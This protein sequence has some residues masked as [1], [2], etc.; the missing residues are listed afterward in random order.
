MVK[1][2]KDLTGQKFGKLTVL[3]QVEDL[4]SKS[5]R[6]YDVWE[7]ECDCGNICTRQGN[8]LK[9]TL[10]KN[11]TPSCEECV[12]EDLTG[13]K[14]GM[15]T[16]LYRVDKPKHLKREDTYWNCKCECGN[17]CVKSRT[18]LVH[19]NTKSC[20]CLVKKHI[21]EYNS[22]R[23]IQ[24]N[25]YDLESEEFGIGYTSKGEP[26][27]FDKED[28]DLI[29]DYCWCYCQGY[30]VSSSYGK[31]IK[32]H[33]LVMGVDDP[34]IKIDHKIHGGY[35]E[36]KYDNRKCNLRIATTSQNG[37]N[38]VLAKNNTSGVTGVCFDK[39]SGKWSAN[40]CVNNER[41]YSYHEY[42]DDA[43]KKRKEY[44]EIFFKE[45][46]YENSQKQISY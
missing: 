4:I 12:A 36:N 22:N 31:N 8:Y 28:Y 14:F 11:I 13:K 44:E 26:F 7:C 27:W 38:S 25:L 19:L 21:E 10:K 45:Y 6:H 35:D 34:K 46:S 2:R 33:R 15:L 17:E 39:A 40:I 43:I 37:M 30:V 41:V 32:L 42:K 29:K 9:K 3:R 24:T 1:V 5:G 20:G 18:N 16:V 23:Q